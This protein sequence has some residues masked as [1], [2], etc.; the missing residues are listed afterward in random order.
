M[1]S[2]SIVAVLIF[3]SAA[4]A[5][6]ASVSTLSTKLSEW[7]A[8]TGVTPIE[9]VITL[10]EDLKTSVEDEGKE[11]A[12]TYDKFACFCKDKTSAKSDAITEGQD[13]ID[14]SS[15]TIEEQTALK[16]EKERELAEFKKMIET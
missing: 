12:T 9:K 1:K 16:V 6:S 2:I 5:V 15:A 10:L 11:E 4:S 8:E 3:L 13:T 7:K 14:A